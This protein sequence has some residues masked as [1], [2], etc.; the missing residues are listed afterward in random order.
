VSFV[1]PSRVHPLYGNAFAFAGEY[2]GISVWPGSPSLGFPSFVRVFQGAVA[3]YSNLDGTVVT[4]YHDDH[5]LEDYLSNNTPPLPAAGTWST[6]VA[7]VILAT[8][9]A[10]AVAR[11]RRAAAG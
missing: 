10:I 7:V 8:G 3:V 5:G 2:G 11:R 4:Y 6:E 9:S 1:I